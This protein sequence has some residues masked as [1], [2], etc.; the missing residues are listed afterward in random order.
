MD[1]QDI[2]RALMFLDRSVE[3]LDASRNCY[4]PAEVLEILCN[5]RYWTQKALEEEMPNYN[6]KNKIYWRER[7]ATN[8]G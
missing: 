8:R 7:P 5:V 3:K 2:D 6:D 4:S 1:K